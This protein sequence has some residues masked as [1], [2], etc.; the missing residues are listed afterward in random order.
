M[1]EKKTYNFVI[2]IG[3]KEKVIIPF[4]RERGVNIS[5]F[6]RMCLEKKYEEEAK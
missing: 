3:E 1:K 2:R 4:L 6:I 5:A